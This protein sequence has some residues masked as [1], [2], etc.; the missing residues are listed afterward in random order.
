M[1]HEAP[2]APRGKREEEPQMTQIS[3]D[4]FFGEWTLAENAKGAKKRK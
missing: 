2:G 4:S 3:A 1:A